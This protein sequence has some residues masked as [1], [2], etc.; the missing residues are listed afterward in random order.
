MPD[1]LG[2]RGHVHRQIRGAG[3][4]DGQQRR[5]QSVARRELHD[6][7]EVAVVVPG[8]GKFHDPSGQ[9]VGR[10]VQLREV[11]PRGTSSEFCAA[12]GL[13]GAKKKNENDYLKYRILP[14]PYNLNRPL[15]TAP[16]TYNRL[17]S[18]R[19]FVYDGHVF[20]ISVFIAFEQ[21]VQFDAFVD[22]HGRPSQVGRSSRMNAHVGSR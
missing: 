18:N 17:N 9:L 12:R 11:E 21:P 5:D 1:T 6:H 3:F 2:G 7:G 4:P 8:A 22:R 15:A 19:T 20:R 14:I 10:G 13:K 16:S